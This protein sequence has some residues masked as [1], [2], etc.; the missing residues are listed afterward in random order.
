MTRSQLLS[1]WRG[2]LA[3]HY[4]LFGAS[5]LDIF[6]AYDVSSSQVC[7]M[8]APLHVLIVC[9]FL[10]W[11]VV[12]LKICVV[13]F[14]PPSLWVSCLFSYLSPLN[15]LFSVMGAWRGLALADGLMLD[16]RCIRVWGDQPP[17]VWR[18]QPQP[19]GPWEP[20]LHGHAGIFNY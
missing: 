10:W 14:P 13:F 15:V 1:T 3:L 9:A 19:L 11:H 5:C 2:V 6:S 18:W 17:W 16:C 4:L 12:W 8:C 7:F 20:N